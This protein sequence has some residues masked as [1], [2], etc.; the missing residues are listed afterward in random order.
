VQRREFLKK[1]GVVAVGAGAGL[2]S[3][4][5]FPSDPQL[6]DQYTKNIYPGAI[7]TYVIGSTSRRYLEGHFN[8]IYIEQILTP[9]GAYHWDDMR[10]NVNAI[11]VPASNAPTWEPYK[12]SLVLAFADQAIAGNEEEAYFTLQLPHEYAEGTDLEAHVHWSPPN[13]DGGNVR[14]GLSYSWANDGAAFPAPTVIYGVGAAGAVADIHIR[15]SL[16][17]IAGAG[18]VISSMLLCK[19]F[20]NSS[21]VLDTY[22]SDAYL[23][24]FDFHYQ[25]DDIGSRQ[26]AVK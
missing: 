7:D 3:S 14:W 19:L 2:F 22:A 23:L 17:T 15:T 6:D 13:G 24:E 1:A 11:K 10:V 8:R 25:K 20:R 12:G 21:N 18:K 9:A 5:G 16:G 26:M 4:C